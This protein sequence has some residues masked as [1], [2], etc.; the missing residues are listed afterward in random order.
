MWLGGFGV[1]AGLG[2]GWLWVEFFGEG[3]DGVQDSFSGGGNQFG[4]CF[5]PFGYVTDAVGAGVESK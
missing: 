4:V 1:V 5:G 3:V 2:A